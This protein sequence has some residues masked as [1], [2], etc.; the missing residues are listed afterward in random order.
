MGGGTGSRMWRRLFGGRQELRTLMVG[1]D[2]AGKTTILHKLKRD[3]EVSTTMPSDGFS[4]ATLDVVGGGCITSFTVWDVGGRQKLRPLLRH[5][6]EAA[7]ALIFVVDS[8]DRDRLDD[9][10]DQL[11]RLLDEE[12]MRDAP[13]LVF[14]NKQDLP[15]ALRLAELTDKLG[16]HRLRARQ[17]YIQAAC[18]R[19]GDGLYEGLDWL[20]ATARKQAAAAAVKRGAAAAAGRRR[21]PGPASTT[22]VAVEWS[23]AGAGGLR[24]EQKMESGSA[25]DTDSTAD[26]EASGNGNAKRT[27]FAAMA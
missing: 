8:T 18:A 11:E 3:G 14:A 21:E 5:Y 16:L 26:T 19:T 2:A 10:R 13:L 15:G 27:A 6:Y 9:A 20:T 7:D 25:S 17:W 24:V 1:L 12:D 22:V 23:A 4:V